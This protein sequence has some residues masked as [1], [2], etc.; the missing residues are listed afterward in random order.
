MTKRRRPFRKEALV[1]C[2]EACEAISARLDSE[3]LPVGDRDLDAHLA[4]CATCRE[5]EAQVLVLAHKVGLRSA[6]PVPKD[7]VAALAAMVEPADPPTT[8]LVRRCSLH[9]AR[10][11]WASRLQWAGIAIPA[12]VAAVAIS[13]GAGT[14][15][16]LVPTRPPSPCT[17]GLA[18][19][20]PSGGG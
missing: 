3:R 20:R 16:H 18:L 8:G 6:R 13:M 11:G 7:L 4:R 12:V 19:H 14:H 9:W 1:G 17:V 5:F 2:E 15:T 10:F